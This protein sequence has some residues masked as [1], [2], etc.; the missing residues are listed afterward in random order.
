MPAL[1][2]I[3]ALAVLAVLAFHVRLPGFTGGFIGV[4]VFFVLSGYLITRLLLAERGAHG[5]VAF[6]AFL[7][8]RMGRLVPALV[9]FLAAIVL[10]YP[11]RGLATDREIGQAAEILP[12]L[13][14][15]SNFTLWMLGVPELTQQ[16]WSL[17][18]E[19]QFYLAWPFVVLALARTD[20]RRACR[21]LAAAILVLWA[22]R[23]LSYDL[24]GWRYAYY[25][26]ETRI[27][28]PMVGRLLV[29]LPGG[30]A[31]RDRGAGAAAWALAVLALMVPAITFY[32]PASALL[33]PVVEVA[34]AVLILAAARGAGSVGR[35]LASGPLVWIG[36]LSY[37]LYLWHYPLARAARQEFPGAAAFAMVFPSA[38]L[39]AWL[40]YR[41][42]EVPA[43]RALARRLA[44]AG[45]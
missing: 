30:M 38:L 23:L 44:G 19:M 26:T 28:A 10:A 27:T 29:F 37:G 35:L 34:A 41:Y 45:A 2:G 8:R 16:G 24:L 18:I 1:D 31:A 15:V 36:Q 9:T 21:L 17:S 25:S 14:Y 42:I 4:E 22:W 39:L 43:R 20:A 11:L 6:G 32:T 12:T 40:S 33:G 5:R 13:L 7:L 3:R